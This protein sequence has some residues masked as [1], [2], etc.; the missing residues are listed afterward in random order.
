MTSPVE[1]IDT[2]AVTQQRVCDSLIQGVI[3]RETR[4]MLTN[5]IIIIIIIIIINK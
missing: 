4:A 5:I 1:V 3:F 2:P